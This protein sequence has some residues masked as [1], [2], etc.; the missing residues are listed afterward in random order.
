MVPTIHDSLPHV[1]RGGRSQKKKK[2]KSGDGKAKKKRERE[3][4]IGDG[5]FFLPFKRRIISCVFWFFFFFVN[6]F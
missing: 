6:S 4:E 2:K 3:R 1:L 5:V